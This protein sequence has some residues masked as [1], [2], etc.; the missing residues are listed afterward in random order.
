MCHYDC[1]TCHIAVTIPSQG[2][3]TIN[4]I[5]REQIRL[6]Y[7]INIACCQVKAPLNLQLT[8]GMQIETYQSCLLQLGAFRLP[9]IEVTFVPIIDL[10]LLSYVCKNS[11]KSLTSC[12]LLDEV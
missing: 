1:H 4:S 12:Q 3:A 10:R 11:S 8:T 2:N 7:F 9:N 6:I 5:K